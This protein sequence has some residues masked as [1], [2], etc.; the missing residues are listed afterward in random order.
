MYSLECYCF[1][2]VFFSMLDWCLRTNLEQRTVQIAFMIE[3]QFTMEVKVIK[4]VSRKNYILV[5]INYCNLHSINPHSS[6]ILIILCD[7]YMYLQHDVRKFI[8]RKT[9]IWFQY[10]FDLERI[11]VFYPLCDKTILISTLS[12][13]RNAI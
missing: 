8:F 4:S 10:T 13:K 7:I 6:N 12:G 9:S 11:L 1:I 5:L 2:F 3:S